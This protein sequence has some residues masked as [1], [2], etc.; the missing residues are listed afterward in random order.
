MSS[1]EIAPDIRG[2]ILALQQALQALPPE[3]HADLDA[4]THHY[5]A[6]GAYARE[7]RIPAGMVI[8]GKIHKTRHIC[9]ISKGDILVLTEDGPQRITAPATIVAPAGTK[10]AVY[11]LADTVWTN[12]HPTHETDLDKIEAQFIAQDYAEIEGGDAAW[13]LDAKKTEI[14]A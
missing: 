2:R 10:R 14:A 5:F 12:F 8:V 6:D 9:V 11:T 1:T 4:M 7:M 3:R 13:I